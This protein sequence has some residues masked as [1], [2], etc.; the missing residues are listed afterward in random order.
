M[1]LIR[2][3]RESL[4]QA[5]GVWR[6]LSELESNAY[7]LLHLHHNDSGFLLMSAL[8]SFKCCQTLSVCV[9]E[10]ERERGGGDRCHYVAWNLLY[11]PCQL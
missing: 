4:R 1:Q 5:P 2:V 8:F 3:R 10:R 6:S 9:C 11:G 7:R